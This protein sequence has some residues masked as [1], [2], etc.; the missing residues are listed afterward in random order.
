MTDPID[1]GG[2]KSRFW[3]QKPMQKLTRKEWEALCDGCG[4]CCLNKLED[5]DTGEIHFTNI[6]CT[7]FDGHSCRCRDYDN[8]FATVPDCVK[9][10]PQ[11]ISKYP[12]LPPH[13]RLSPA[14]RG[15]GTA[16]LAPADHRRSRIGPPRRHQRPNQSSDSAMERATSS[17]TAKV[18]KPHSLDTISAA[19]ER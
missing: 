6:A 18:L 14:G 3:E 5:W 7:L 8:R 1:R 16:R 15:A 2:L 10:E 4:K 9:L 12:W 11:D 17:A 19:A 13:M